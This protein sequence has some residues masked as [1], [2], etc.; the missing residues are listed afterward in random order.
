MVAQRAT[1]LSRFSPI[2]SGYPPSQGCVRNGR[3]SNRGGVFDTDW[4]YVNFANDFPEYKSEHINVLELLTVLVAARRWGHLWSG[5]H[6]GVLS[7]NSATV[8]AINKGSSRLPKFMLCLRE[9][10]WLAHNFR[11]SA[12]HI[13]G[14]HNIVAD[15]VSRLDE[16]DNLCRFINMFA[17][18]E[19]NFYCNM[20]LN[21]FLSL[22]LQ[23]PGLS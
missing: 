8:F 13:K 22:P 17:G 4:F 19:L 3:L 20:T 12:A 7:D 18:C 15:L 16:P 6:I 23:I 1:S 11:I 21:A 2:Y 9:L 14:E 10:F 5:S